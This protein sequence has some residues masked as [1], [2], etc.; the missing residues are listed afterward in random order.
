MKL[1]VARVILKDG[2][3]LHPLTVVANDE[4]HATTL[5]LHYLSTKG[6]EEKEISVWERPLTALVAFSYDPADPDTRVIEHVGMPWKAI[7]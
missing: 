1:F 3:I 2:N 4:V 7:D 6:I 5:F